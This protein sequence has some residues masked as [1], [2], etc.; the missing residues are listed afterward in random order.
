MSFDPE[1]IGA[2]AGSG[3]L[4]VV[5]TFFGFKGRLDRLE[6]K[7]DEGVV[8]LT[9]HQVCVGATVGRLDKIEKRLGTLEQNN[10]EQTGLLH[11]IKGSLEGKDNGQR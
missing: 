7:V 8:P 5:L 2:G 10:I 4:G 11:E 3:A 9:T 6:K 1:T